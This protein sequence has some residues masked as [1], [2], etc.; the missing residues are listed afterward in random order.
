[1]HRQAFV[2]LLSL[3]FPGVTLGY[4]IIDG[5]TYLCPGVAEITQ[6]SNGYCC[7]GGQVN[8]TNCE[9]WPI[10]QGPATITHSTVCATEIPFTASNYDDLVTSA[11]SMYL[12]SDGSITATAGGSGAALATSTSS[13][14]SASSQPSS[15]AGAMKAAATLLAPACM[16]LLAYAAL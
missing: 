1:M 7:V 6:G 14:S 16:G 15:T 2:P 9:G 8:N 13:G 4:D 10:C 11:S 3:L 5:T 12:N